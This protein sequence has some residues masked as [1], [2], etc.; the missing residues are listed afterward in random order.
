[1]CGLKR[2][3][4]WVSWVSV[5]G[6]QAIG[7]EPCIHHA[8]ADRDLGGERRRLVAVLLAAVEGDARAAVLHQLHHRPLAAPLM[9]H[10]RADRRSGG[11]VHRVLLSLELLLAAV[12]EGDLGLGAHHPVRLVGD[13]RRE[14][15]LRLGGVDWCVGGAQTEGSMQDGLT[16]GSG[17][18][19]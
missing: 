5:G 8:P 2:W 17:Y 4:K 19:G 12:H 11:A 16:R 7:A 10:A 1:M 13:D 15:H 9:R 18:G 14:E 3:A 6:C